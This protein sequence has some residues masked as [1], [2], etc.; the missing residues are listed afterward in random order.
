MTFLAPM[1][2]FLMILGASA[3]PPPEV[4]GTIITVAA[5][6]ITAL[7][8]A[9][10][11]MNGRV[12]KQAVTHL[13]G[14]IDDLKVSNEKGN[15]KMKADIGAIRKEVV[16]YTKKVIAIEAVCKSRHGEISKAE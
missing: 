15:D 5:S 16:V 9:I 14:K 7:I 13:S 6:V 8:V 2:A 3:P 4:S 11:V 10:G 12:V 1:Y